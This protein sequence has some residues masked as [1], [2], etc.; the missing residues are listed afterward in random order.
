MSGLKESRDTVNHLSMHKTI[1]SVKTYWTPTISV[2]IEL[3]RP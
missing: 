3:V 2:L 1:L